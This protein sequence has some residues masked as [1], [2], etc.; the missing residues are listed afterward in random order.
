LSTIEILTE[1]DKRRLALRM[2]KTSVS[3]RSGVSL[4]TVNRILS[5]S[6]TKPNLASVQAI[7][8]AL[9][10]EIK[11]EPIQNAREFRRERA[12]Q[13]AKRLVKMVQGTMALEA[14]AV[15]SAILDEL[16]EETADQLA[17]AGSRR[18]WDD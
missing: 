7:A 1:L 11:I 10:L 17:V 12:K 2:S 8:G 16:V 3:R 5:G 13:K 15:E 6:E 4:P 14:Q 9:G 18:L